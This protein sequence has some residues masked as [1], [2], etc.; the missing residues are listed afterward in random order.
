MQTRDDFA[1]GFVCYI[2]TE[3]LWSFLWGP[4][5]WS[6][7][8]QTCLRGL[9]CSSFQ[10]RANGVWFFFIIIQMK[11]VGYEHAL[12]DPS[13]ASLVQHSEG[14]RQW[15]SAFGGFTAQHQKTVY[16][17]ILFIMFWWDFNWTRC[18]SFESCC[19]TDVCSSLAR[20]SVTQISTKMK[21][22][23]TSVRHDLRCVLN[24]VA[25]LQPFSVFIRALSFCLFYCSFYNEVV[26][27]D[28]Q[29]LWC[30]FTDFKYLMSGLKSVWNSRPALTS[31]IPVKYVLIWR[32]ITHLRH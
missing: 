31:L 32:I 17:F 16:F 13:L 7:S 4:R 25:Q 28:D 3:A 14:F 22:D 9:S 18:G 2:E 5:T 8:V 10:T 1:L 27:C 12:L 26:L 11:T 19:N 15:W 20:S 23:H 24:G 29:K 21:P 30:S 6:G